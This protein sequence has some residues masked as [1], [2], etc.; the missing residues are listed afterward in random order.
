MSMVLSYENTSGFGK[1]LIYRSGTWTTTGVSFS[2]TTEGIY[3][4]TATGN[5][6]NAYIQHTS[7]V[8]DSSELNHLCKITAHLSLTNGSFTFGGFGVNASLKATI[9]NSSGEVISSGAAYT[10][11][12]TGEYDLEYI[13]T[14]PS[15]CANYLI[16]FN[17]T[18]GVQFTLSDV[19]VEIVGA[20]ITISPYTYRVENWTQYNG[21]KLPISSVTL[22]RALY[23]AP[24]VTDAAAPEYP[25]QLRFYNDNVYI[26]Y[27]QGTTC[28]WKQ[29]SN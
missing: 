20:T 11:T 10:F 23:R 14:I 26:G 27:I 12:E 21:D 25:G 2:G 1:R 28:V 29:I 7:Y 22:S 6:S 18:S 4:V 9:Y 16:Q 5:N 8:F 19:Y 3:N 15:G 17:I 13:G 24:I